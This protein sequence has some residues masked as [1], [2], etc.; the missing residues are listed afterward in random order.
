MALGTSAVMAAAATIASG[1]ATAGATVAAAAT[2][3]I[4][5]GVVTSVVGLTLKVVGTVTRNKGLAEAGTYMS[6]AGGALTV[7][8]GIASWAAAPGAE[9]AVGETMANGAEVAGDIGGKSVAE[10]LT[11]TATPGLVDPSS[12]IVAAPG[13]IAST[14]VPGSDA[15]VAGT[16]GSNVL[17]GGTGTDPMGTQAVQTLPPADVAAPV[18]GAGLP[19]GPPIQPLAPAL[20][21][22]A[23]TYHIPLAD[24]PAVGY[25]SA[26]PDLVGQVGTHGYG[27]A[28]AGAG[29]ITAPPAGG[30]FAWWN[31]LPD[32]MKAVIGLSAG[33]TV[34]GAAGGVFQGMAAEDKLELERQIQGW[35][36]RNAAY[37][38][39]V[40][41]PG[42]I[43]T[44]RRPA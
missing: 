5:V 19:G 36:Q 43:N 16:T 8:G 44:P 26:V 17:H 24:Q 7:A 3:A 9:A 22:P 11:Q 14:G 38:P 33:Q 27:A 25:H 29:G 32:S 6:Y 23:G 34:A 15:V 10:G 31:A 12:S 41:F 40:S 35:K 28:T 21:P 13:S 2:I 20:P 4:N 37:A 39:K 30:V 1:T 42:L 18:S